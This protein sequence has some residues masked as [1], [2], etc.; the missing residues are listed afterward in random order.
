V[1]C[2]DVTDAI[3]ATDAMRADPRNVDLVDF[4]EDL[5]GW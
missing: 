2:I 1:V 3:D 4:D 5:A